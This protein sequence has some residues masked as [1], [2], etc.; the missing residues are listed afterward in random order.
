MPLRSLEVMEINRFQL[1]RTCYTTDMTVGYGGSF[2][3]DRRYFEILG[4]R[5][6]RLRR[7]L[8][9]YRHRYQTEAK[10]ITVPD[11]VLW[12]K[13]DGQLWNPRPAPYLDYWDILHDKL[14][15]V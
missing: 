8:L 1:V 4:D 3:P 14:D 2:N 12:E 5:H 15:E 11:P 10:S 13:T 6:S 7:I 9:T